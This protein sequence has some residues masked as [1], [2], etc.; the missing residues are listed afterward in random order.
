MTTRLV[1]FLG[2]GKMGATPPYYEFVRYEWMGQISSETPLVEQAIVELHGAVDEVVLL[3]TS[4]V[5]ERWIQSRELEKWLRHPFK[6]KRVAKGSD[7]S[8]LRE[9]FE[10]IVLALGVSWDDRAAEEPAKQILLDV[11]HGYRI[12]PILATAALSFALSEWR[13][14]G[15]TPPEVRVLYGAYDAASGD[16]PRPI[17]DLTEIVTVA[18]WNAALDAMLRYGRADDIESLAS[19]MAKVAVSEARARGE[20]GTDLGRWSHIKAIG[21]AARRFSDDLALGRM[22]ELLRTSAP[23][24][25]QKLRDPRTEHW[26]SEL[27]LLRG[28]VSELARVVEDLCLSQGR[29]GGPEG[30]RAM[31]PLARHYGRIQRFAEQAATLREALVSLFGV[32]GDDGR[33]PDP[34]EKGCQEARARLEGGLGALVKRIHDGERPGGKDEGLGKLAGNVQPVRNDIEHLGFN[35]QPA[36]SVS[37]RRSL[38]QLTGDFASLVEQVLGPAP[39]PTGAVAGGALDGTTEPCFVNISNHPSER[40][41]ADQ[42]RAAEALG[43]RIVDIPFPAV[44]PEAQTDDLAALA[45]TIIANVPSGCTHAMVMG[46]FTLTLVLVRRLQARGV[47]CVVAAGPRKAEELPDGEKLSRFEFVTFREYPAV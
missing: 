13:R 5:E 37:L 42:R 23:D 18:N 7:V 24:L 11:T 12:Q 8:Q 28:A 30:I 40:W 21:G 33:K 29:I 4:D 1:S 36:S 39:T 2:L 20:E 25:L 47:S 3:G 9:L 14:R 17:W 19:A 44:P 31:V 26:V 32:I 15:D 34:G 43:G 22:R 45:E 10:A 35:D 46:E 16:V 6:F 38:G 41:S 27:P